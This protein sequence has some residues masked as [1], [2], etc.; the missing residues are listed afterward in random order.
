MSH[1][2]PVPH[3][4]MRLVLL[5]ALVASA[6]ALVWQALGRP[7][8]LPPSPLGDG[9]KLSC[10][11]YAPFHGDDGPYAIP[12][13]VAEKRI[14]ED[15]QRLAKVTR[16]IRTYSAAG[17]QARVT[18]LAGEFG[19]TVLQGIWIGRNR[20]DTRREIEAALRLARHH[21]DVVKALI[22]GNEVLLR[23]EQSAPRLKAYLDEVRRRSG[24]PVTYADVWE[25]WLKAPELAPAVDFVTIHIL[26][27]WED[28]P[29]PAEDAAAHVGNIRQKVAAAFPGKEILIGEV[30]WPSAGRMRDGALPSPANQAL[31]LSGVVAAAKE[32]GWRVNLIEAFDQPW[33][34]L[35]E[36]TVGGYWGL[37]GDRS[38]AL[39][40]HW[41]VPVSNHPQWRLEATLGIGAALLVFA[42]AWIFGR[43]SDPMSWGESLAIAAIA[44]A[45]GLAFGAA[46]LG[47]PTE[48]PEL[49]DRLR[50]AGMIVLSLLV[51]VAA[52]IAVARAE[53][54][55]GFAWALNASLRRRS[56][57]WSLL[58]AGLFAAAIVAAIH[59]A[60]G[61][62]FDPRYK[63]FQLALLS[64]PAAAFAV[65]ALVHGPARPRPGVAE[66]TA[67]ALLAASAAYVVANEGVANWQALWFSGLI[68]VLA[69]TALW[70]RP[71]PS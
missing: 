17:S 59:V 50:S 20:A 63:G 36:G 6:I 25:F 24:L 41:G 64:G 39:K 8:A 56:D 65:V 35:L 71:A 33:K 18:R 70:A 2:E 37:Y 10:L 48:P 69:V 19:L 45:S 4:L 7:V 21:P 34:R 9:D 1:P 27:Y 23:G 12:L 16:C 62:V 53:A 52:G 46:L 42:G 55:N 29:V 31:V 60:L 3:R 68:L 66:S 43:R 38:R 5:F 47:L 32:G 22:V 51:P 49:G 14:A 58:L 26:P 11:S 15:M 44:L 30:G 13:R 54:L 28:E 57:G 61:L 40:F 67:A